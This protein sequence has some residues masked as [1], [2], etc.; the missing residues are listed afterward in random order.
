M[1]TTSLEKTRSP[2]SGSCYARNR[3][4]DAE[5]GAVQQEAVPK[6]MPT[7]STKTA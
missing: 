1:N 3:V 4:C 6:F 7:D 2:V 5:A